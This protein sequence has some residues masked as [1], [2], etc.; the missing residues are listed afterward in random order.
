MAC[1]TDLFVCINFDILITFSHLFVVSCQDISDP[2][3]IIIDVRSE[4]EWN[5]G[6]LDCAHLLTLNKSFTKE[7]L[8]RL[9]SGNKHGKLVIYCRLGRRAGRAVKQAINWGYTDV[10]NALGY[11]DIINSGC[12][13]SGKFY[14]K[15][16]QKLKYEELEMNGLSN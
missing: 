11:D 2:K 4:S 10:T 12:G 15:I 6:H 16:S 5:M 9:T 8:A 7:N 14:N 1:R 3:S 13:C